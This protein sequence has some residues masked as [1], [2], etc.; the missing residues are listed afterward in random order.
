MPIMAEHDRCR[1]IPACGVL[2]NQGD[3]LYVFELAPL[4]SSACFMLSEEVTT[5][6]LGYLQHERELQRLACRRFP[7]TLTGQRIE[8]SVLSSISPSYS[9]QPYLLDRTST[10]IS[11]RTDDAVVP[12]PHTSHY[13]GLCL[14]RSCRL[15][16]LSSRLRWRCDGLL[17]RRGCYLG[18]HPRCYCSS[19]RG[20]LQCGIRHLSG[21]LCGDFVDANTLKRGRCPKPLNEERQV[22]GLIH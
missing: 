7:D 9:F 11:C 3:D 17:Y 8:A 16:S 1:W 18:R 19:H 5:S 12:S 20:R 21:C 10:K 4:W 22:T 15:R 13:G 2:W 6:H 14:G